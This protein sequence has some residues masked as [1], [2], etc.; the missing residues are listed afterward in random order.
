MGELDDVAEL[1][2]RARAEAW[3]V[4][5]EA[6]R[7]LAGYAGEPEVDSTLDELLLDSADTAVSAAT[8]GGLLERRDPVGLR[9]YLSALSRADDD[10]YYHLRDALLVVLQTQEDFA[11]LQARLQDLAVD[12]DENVRAGAVEVAAQVPG[13]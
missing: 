8:A 10:T 6:G 5:A 3:A 7:R 1:L 4:R 11:G 12:E 9:L 2:S 13:L